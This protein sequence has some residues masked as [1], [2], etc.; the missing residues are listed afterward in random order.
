M[1]ELVHVGK[2]K[3]ICVGCQDD[4]LDN[5][6]YDLV[7]STPVQLKYRYGEDEEWIFKTF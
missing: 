6:E 1:G 5:L 2:R 3:F 7:Q 4:S